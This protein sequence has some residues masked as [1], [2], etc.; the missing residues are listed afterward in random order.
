MKNNLNPVVKKSVMLNF[1]IS[2][3]ESNQLDVLCLKLG[4]TNKSLVLRSALH[5]FLASHGLTQVR[6]LYP[7]QPETA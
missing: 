5:Y 1:K 6:N 4:E 3:F 7:E 2:P